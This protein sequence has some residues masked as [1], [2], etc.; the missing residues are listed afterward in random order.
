MK[1]LYCNGDTGDEE[2]FAYNL[3]CFLKTKSVKSSFNKILNTHY[4]PKLQEEINTN[5]RITT[6]FFA[7]ILRALCGMSRNCFTIARNFLKRQ[8]DHP[9]QFLRSWYS[10]TQD[11]SLI[12]KMYPTHLSNSAVYSDVRNTIKQFFEQPNIREILKDLD[13]GLDIIV[14]G[15]AFNIVRNSKKNNN[16]DKFNFEKL[17]PRIS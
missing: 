5:T 6:R 7:L 2:T 14:S 9:S 4:K 13:S 12:Y 17:E 3:H 15:D 1:N 11:M 10:T 16:T 8:Y